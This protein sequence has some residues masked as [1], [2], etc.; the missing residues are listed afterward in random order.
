LPKIRDRVLSTVDRRI[1]NS[2]KSKRDAKVVGDAT[3][4]VTLDN[5][6]EAAE[7]WM[8]NVMM[9]LDGGNTN[10]VPRV[11]LDSLGMAEVSMGV[12]R[13]LVALSEIDALNS[14]RHY[15]T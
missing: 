7:K 12:L 2:K 3:A 5:C 13:M 9:T 4:Q 15:I 6:V 1:G 10:Y 14:M 8:L 11:V